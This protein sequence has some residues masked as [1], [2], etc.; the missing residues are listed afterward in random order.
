M[1][2]HV[3]FEPVL[4]RAHLAT[5]QVSINC[6]NFFRCEFTVEVVL[7]SLKDFAA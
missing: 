6:G 2:K 4:V 3:G 7:K 1:S 5:F